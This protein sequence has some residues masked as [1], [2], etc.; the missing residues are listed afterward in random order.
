MR[1]LKVLIN[2]PNISDKGGV[3]NHF[4]GLKDKFQNEI[5][6]NYIG[7]KSN[8][9][10]FIFYQLIDYFIF[11]K[12]IFV[13]K[14]DIVHL[15]P[16]LNMKATIR[17]GIF[18]M[19]ARLFNVKILVFW[20]GWADN[21]GKKI[22]IRYS[23]LFKYV[24]NKTNA[25]CV[26]CTDFENTL[27][28]WGIDKPIYIETTKVD[29]D[30]I[31]N[32]NIN[33]KKYGNG[34]LF[35]ARVEKYKGIYI[36][37]EAVKN[38]SDVKLTIAGSGNELNNVKK[39]VSDRNIENVEFIGYVS[40]KK[41]IETYTNSSIYLL[42]SDA[43][44]MPTSI[45]EAMA[46]GLPVITRP[47]GGIKDFFEDGKMGYIT[48]SKDPKVYIE[49]IKNLLQNK[50]KIKEIGRYNHEYAKK[51]FLASKVAK[52]LENIYEEVYYAK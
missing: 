36:C 19:I 41:L 37:L 51:R 43:E 30:I 7:D 3:S 31:K 50:E 5:E 2:T 23:K 10:F 25:F 39:Y 35:L 44:G 48:E 20:H 27:K 29:D 40:G 8:S 1:R 46:F 38:I 14:P 52:R 34:L 18:L 22:S 17:D 12:K 47:V 6:Y 26:L 16:S 11:F 49:L 13:Y 28:K 9:K 33:N 24:Y 4:L 42:P 45:L 32:F 21:F 15:N